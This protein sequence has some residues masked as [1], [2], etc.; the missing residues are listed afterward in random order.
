MLCIICTWTTENRPQLVVEPT[1]LNIHII[2]GSEL[3]VLQCIA[4]GASTYTWEWL[5]GTITTKAVLKEGDTIL[6]IPNIRREEAGDYRCVARNSAGTSTSEYAR[7]TVTGK[8]L[9]LEKQN[10]VLL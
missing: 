5:G 10:P 2:N 3:A 4:L 8:G 7:I 9:Y 1:D 6:E